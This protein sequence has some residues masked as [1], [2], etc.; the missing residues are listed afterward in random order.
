MDFV[1]VIF[2]LNKPS[3]MEGWEIELPTSPRWLKDPK[4]FRVKPFWLLEVPPEE[5]HPPFLRFRYR[6]I[7]SLYLNLSVRLHFHTVTQNIL[8]GHI[9][10]HPFWGSIPLSIIFMFDSW[11]QKGYKELKPFVH[12]LFYGDSLDLCLIYFYE[13]LNQNLTLETWSQRYWL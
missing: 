4:E 12:I 9:S 10:W 6:L 13:F 1:V 5:P 7:S 2:G 11:Y 3:F 8:Q